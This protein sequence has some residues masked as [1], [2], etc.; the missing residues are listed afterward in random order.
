MRRSKSNVAKFGRPRS[1]RKALLQSLSESLILEE[2]IETTLPKAK[3]VARHTEKLISQAKKSQDSLHSRR[4]VLSGLNTVGAA[5]KLV[6]EIAPKLA[7]RPSGYFRV[8]RLATRRGDNAQMAKISF[9]DNLKT[10][11]KSQKSQVS[12]TTEKETDKA[13]KSQTKPTPQAIKGGDSKI[14]PKMTTQA[15]KRAGVRGNR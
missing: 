8:E 7:S 3:A 6:D 4:I 9:V 1:Q 14:Q 15:P 2:A 12:Q 13:S 10:A 11:K 5:H